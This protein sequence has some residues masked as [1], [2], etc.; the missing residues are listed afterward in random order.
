MS[1]LVVDDI[2]VKVELASVFGFE[3]TGLE[4]DYHEGPQSQVVEQ[5]INVKIR[6]INLDPLLPTDKSEALPE[7]EQKFLEVT[8]KS[9]F[10]FAFL[11][12]FRQCEEIEYI[13]IFQRL[14]YQ[15]GLRCRKIQ[16]EIGDSLPL[17]A[18]RIRF[19]HQ[20]ENVAAPA[21]GK[22]LLHVPTA[23]GEIGQF[24]DQ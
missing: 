8:Y 7:L 16:I 13:G 2:A 6:V 4:V 5:Q 20:R 21:I 12:R 14:P 1:E 19:D 11:E 3:R 18:V 24:L 15:V 22:R 23:G 9:G 17:A 10:E